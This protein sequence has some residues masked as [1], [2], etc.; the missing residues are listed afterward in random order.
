M[1]NKFQLDMGTMFEL[2]QVCNLDEASAFFS[3]NRYGILMSPFRL[4][5]FRISADA[6]Q[7]FV[8]LLILLASF[9]ILALQWS[10]YGPLTAS[11]IDE[12]FERCVVRS[13]ET[14][15]A[16]FL[17]SETVDKAFVLLLIGLLAGRVWAWIGEG[18]VT[19]AEQQP[20]TSSR[21]RMCFSISLLSSLI[22]DAFM[23]TYTAE[24]VMRNDVRR[25]MP[26]FAFEFGSLT[27][28]LTLKAARY[29]LSLT[30]SY[31]SRRKPSGRQGTETERSISNE[32]E[33][34][35]QD[36]EHVE[37]V[38]EE[39]GEKR[40]WILYVRLGIGKND[41]EFPFLSLNSYSPIGLS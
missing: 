37:D 7:I 1:P 3:E 35:E 5:L 25:T 22:F 14:F 18:R 29:G 15:L 12:I 4:P 27:L 16:T 33:E 28:S 36:Q 2:H 17:V 20:S 19:W 11:E 23:F 24:T 6:K 31:L 34:Y 39:W 13:A 8:N 21:L 10:L 26:M 32:K 30:E 40:Q 9:T 38:F 41:F